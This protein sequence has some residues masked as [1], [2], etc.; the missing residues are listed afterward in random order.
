L[1]HDIIFLDE[2]IGAGDAEFL[3][4]ARQRLKSQVEGSKIVVVATHNMKMVRRLC[5]KAILLEKGV[6]LGDGPTKEII[7][8]YRKRIDSRKRPALAPAG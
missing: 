4:K 2:W 8:L 5:N 3:N 1:Q 7:D 6:I